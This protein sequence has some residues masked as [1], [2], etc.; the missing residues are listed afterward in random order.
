MCNCSNGRFLEI[1]SIELIGRAFFYVDAEDIVYVTEHNGGMVSSLTLEG[2]RMARWGGR[3]IAPVTASGV[4]H[5]ATS[6]WYSQG[7]ERACPTTP[8]PSEKKQMLVCHSRRASLA[9]GLQSLTL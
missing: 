1:W 7:S 2:K 3:S 5:S 8:S 6:T 4:T 9:S